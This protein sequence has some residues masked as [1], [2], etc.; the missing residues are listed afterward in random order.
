MATVRFVIFLLAVGLVVAGI[1]LGAIT[2]HE[3]IQR[4]DI[5][6]QGAS[7][8][9]GGSLIVVT[10]ILV[11]LGV[12]AGS[13]ALSRQ[14]APGSLLSALGLGVAAWLLI[15][16][17]QTD[18]PN[19][20]S[21]SNLKEAQLAQ[22]HI[23]LEGFASP[24]A[25][26]PVLTLVAGGLAAAGWGAYR[27]VSSG[28][29]RRDA[30]T[31]AARHQA[32]VAFA[33][34][35][36][37]ITGIGH[38]RVLL[39]VPS[40]SSSAGLAVVLLPLAAL[41]SV[42]LIIVLLLRQHALRYW[43]ED[44][45]M[46]A[47]AAD[48]TWTLDRIQWALL[49][50]LAV[51]AV[52]STVLEKRDMDVLAVGR[53]FILTLRSHGQATAFLVLPLL[54]AL[55]VQRRIRTQLA[56]DDDHVPGRLRGTTSLMVTTVFSAILATV[57][58]AATDMALLPW[59]AASVPMALWAVRGSGPLT[60]AAIMA[61]TGWLLWARGDSV[62]AVYDGQEFP[63]LSYV[64]P[65][66]LLALWRIAAVLLWGWAIVRMS[67]H[68]GRDEPSAIRVPLAIVVAVGTGLTLLLEVPL[69]V[70]V[71]AGGAQDTVAVGSVIASQTAAVA[72]TMHVLATLSLLG[73][74]AA[75]A[76]LMRPEWFRRSGR[77]HA[78]HVPAP[79]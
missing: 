35:F 38:I 57:A 59:I 65:P 75:L 68:A 77:P 39:D 7:A 47:V 34:P 10:G 79:A 49:G 51:A 30:F 29:G 67:N 33:V 8:S 53:T 76:R 4:S 55:L 24:S 16:L 15:V 1:A 40:S 2:Q 46:R 56:I 42:G 50:T 18:F 66:G 27:L 64:T 32:A 25:L 74:G 23:T 31:L 12:F 19:Y 58:L 6:G 63:P 13:A 52:A 71:E 36:L 14:E 70:W 9:A 3:Q 78:S 48:N 72:A 28:P 5:E 37:V 73:A 44:P 21:V 69:A 41:A 61:F 26:T 20:S 17:F 60:G 43:A 45:R 11:G 22:N 62:E 54:P